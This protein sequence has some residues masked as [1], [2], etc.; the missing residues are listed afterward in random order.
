[1]R[2]EDGVELGFADQEGVVVL[3]EAGGIH[4]V[5]R[6]PVGDGERDERPPRR[7]GRHAEDAGQ[8][9]GRG[10]LVGGWDDGVVQLNGH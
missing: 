7:G 6:D 8:E 1:M 9:L 3:S 5:E 2:F 10:A 4:E